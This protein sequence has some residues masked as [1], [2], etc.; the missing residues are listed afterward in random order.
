MDGDGDDDTA[1][2][3]DAQ[4][5]RMSSEQFRALLLTNIVCIYWQITLLTQTQQHL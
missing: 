5:E 4:L 1:L 3:D 2:C